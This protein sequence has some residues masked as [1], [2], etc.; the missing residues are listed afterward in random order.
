MYTN[1]FIHKLKNLFFELTKLDNKPTILIGLDKV[2]DFE[3]LDI[4]KYES[5]GLEFRIVLDHFTYSFEEFK[6]INDKL[7][8]YLEK[9]INDNMRPY[10]K[11]ISI[12]NFIRKFK[13]YKIVE[14]PQSESVSDFLK[15]LSEIVDNKN[16]SCNLKYI[17]EN[18]NIDCLGF[19]KLLQ[20][21][22]NKVG[23]ESSDFGFEVYDNTGSFIGGH[24]RT[25]LNLD[26]DKYDIHGIFISDATDAN[27]KY[28][29]LPISS[30]RNSIYSKCNET[31]LFDANNE[32]EFI[33]NLQRLKQTKSIYNLTEEI[34]RMIYVIDR[35]ESDKLVKLNSND[36]LVEVEKYILSRTNKKINDSN[37]IRRNK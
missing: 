6:I 19:S 21:L 35:K 3:L 34:I 17:L 18:D 25:I 27:L 4:E 14:Q 20:T 16:Q 13:E 36:L 8:S 31:L 12:Y 26:D 5:L 2:V 10:E 32:V 9:L 30:M 37:I 7:N 24:A 33:N 23:I 11:Y 29:L 28:S 1:A 22:L 15:K